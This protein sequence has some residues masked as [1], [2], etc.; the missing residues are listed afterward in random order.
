MLPKSC[1]FGQKGPSLLV[2]SA[3]EGAWALAVLNSRVY[4]YLLTIGAGAADID[5]GSISKS[6]GAGLIQSVPVPS[7]SSSAAAHLAM[8]CWELR[9]ALSAQLDVTSAHFIGFPV[10][11]TG[12]LPVA[13]LSSMCLRIAESECELLDLWASL[14][15]KVLRAYGLTEAHIRELDDEV[16]TL[17]K[18]SI[19]EDLAHNQVVTDED[20]EPSGYLAPRGWGYMR[21][22]ARQSGM[23]PRDVLA[24]LRLELVE[25]RELLKPFASEALEFYFG[26]AFGVWQRSGV[27]SANT[28]EEMFSEAPREPPAHGAAPSALLVDDPGHETDLHTRIVSIADNDWPGCADE[29]LRALVDL[30]GHGSEPRLYFAQNFFPEHIRR[31]SRSRRKAP[32]FWQLATPSSSYSV[33]LYLHALAR[34]TLYKILNEYVAPKL[35]HAERQ[36]EEL[37][38]DFGL[39]S[40]APERKQLAMKEAFVGELRAFADEFK[41]VAPLWNPNLDDGVIIN[42]APLWR[43]VPHSKSW[44]RQLK[45]TWNALAA[46]DLDW[47][48]LAMH[49]WPERVVAKCGVDRSLAIAHKLEDVFWEGEDG[50]WKPRSTP[51]RS[52]TELVG[53]RTSSSVKAALKNLLEAPVASAADSRGRGRRATTAA[54]GG[55]R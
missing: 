35:A 34:D 9:R 43:L 44:Q 39:N 45:V 1:I 26:A 48:H 38:I 33:W 7:E 4:Q 53:E 36:L 31:F 18:A 6:Y 47:A 42:F 16:G 17:W 8:Q 29:T 2:A 40:K 27:S 30:A 23:S 32:I 11:A 50:K 55:A 49:L 51:K 3:S 41:L 28:F 22:N 24:G 46:G 15:D 19:F 10:P 54:G 20:E 25:S 14:S 37:R 5:P 52:V 21:R 13:W 12:A